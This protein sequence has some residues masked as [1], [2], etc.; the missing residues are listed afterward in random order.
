MS[1]DD[2]RLRLSTRA[3]IDSATAVHLVEQKE[4]LES[5]LAN[6]DI[7]LTLD[8][9]KAFLESVFKTILSDRV[10]NP[11]LEGKLPRLY[12]EV[13]EEVQFSHDSKAQDILQ[14]MGSNIVR[15]IAELRNK[16]GA[17]SH[18]DDGYFENPIEL[19][20]LEMV[21]S[22]VD[23]LASC[24]YTKHRSSLHPRTASRI[25]Y[26]SYPEFNDWLDEQFSEYSLE[27]SELTIIRFTASR[28]IYTQEIETYKEM[29]LQYSST[30]EEDE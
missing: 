22:A 26:E 7:S 21:V 10:D 25:H 20:E 24:L 8:L 17:A 6:Y 18:G 29:L 9:A 15:T 11:K 2:F 3:I 27:L 13:K 14:Q 30:E 23:G 4:R 5:A 1:K 16:F 12:K 19:P 28:L